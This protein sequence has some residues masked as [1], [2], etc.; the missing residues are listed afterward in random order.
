MLRSQLDFGT[1]LNQVLEELG[2]DTLLNSSNWAKLGNRVE[3]FITLVFTHNIK[4]DTQR[5][6]LTSLEA[7]LL[8]LE[9]HPLMRTA[10]QKQLPQVLGKSF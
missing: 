8:S 9:A 3:L 5:V 7:R 2:I 1:E 6:T 10:A 4:S